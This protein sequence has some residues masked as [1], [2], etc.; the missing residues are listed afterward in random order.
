MGEIILQYFSDNYTM[1]KKLEKYKT[2]KKEIIT[3]NIIKKKKKTE[4]MLNNIKID[5]IF[6]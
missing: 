1:E 5:T 2:E 6:N 4:K 3:H